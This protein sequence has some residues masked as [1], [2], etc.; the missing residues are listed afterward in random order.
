MIAFLTMLAVLA[1]RSLTKHDDSRPIALGEIASHAEGEWERLADGS[2]GAVT[3]FPGA[4]GVVIP[5]YLREPTRP[6]PFPV[7]VLLHGGAYGKETT[8]SLG[9][10]SPPAG[11]FARAG[12][13]VFAIDY[14]TDSSPPPSVVL[15]DSIEAVNTVRKLA[16][17]DPQRAGLMGGS[18][19]RGVVSRLISRIDCKGAV[20]CGPAG[21]DL[22]EI[23]NA[24]TRGLGWSQG[25]IGVFESSNPVTGRFCNR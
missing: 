16:L 19:G 2:L 14:R 21:I 6:G 12:W 25:Q 8:W 11:E 18:R 23:K 13:V 7:V 15:Q 5:A 9:R 17:V 10:S 22:I 1:G 3:E 24:A 4:G 20:L